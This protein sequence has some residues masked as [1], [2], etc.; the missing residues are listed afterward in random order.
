MFA[1]PRRVIIASHLWTGDRQLPTSPEITIPRLAWE[2][3]AT[4]VRKSSAQL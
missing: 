3:V 2:D 4:Q 1:T